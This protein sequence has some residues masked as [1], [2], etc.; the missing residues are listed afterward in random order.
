[1]QKGEKVLQAKQVFMQNTGIKNHF[2]KE[3]QA[4]WFVLCYAEGCVL[5][6]FIS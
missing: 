5:Q 1:M 2:V 6:K 4:V 3:H